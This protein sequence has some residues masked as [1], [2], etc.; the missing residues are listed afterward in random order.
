[1]TDPCESGTSQESRM[2]RHL[3]ERRR[4]AD[5]PLIFCSQPSY[6]LKALTSSV[7]LR[8]DLS[9]NLSLP[10]QKTERYDSNQNEKFN[11]HTKIMI[12]DEQPRNGHA[13][14]NGN[15]SAMMMV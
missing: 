11:G 6:F 13:T 4:Y 2:T 9:V 7:H 15:Q 8:N 12:D 14:Q 3:V 5:L 10:L 1:M